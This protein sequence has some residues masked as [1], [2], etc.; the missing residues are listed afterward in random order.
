MSFLRDLVS[1]L[2]AELAAGL[3]LAA[4]AYFYLESLLDVRRERKQRFA[5][6]RDFLAVVGDELKRNREAR[7]VLEENLRRGALPYQAFEVGGWS[8]LSQAPVLTAVGRDTVKD[9]T[10]VYVKLRAANEQHAL[11]FDFTYGSTGALSVLLAAGSMTPAAR[12][13]YAQIEARREDLKER[14]L[15]RI[16]DLREPLER[17]GDAVT[18]EVRR[19]AHSYL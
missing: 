9:L 2:I 8:L 11:L 4:L 19:P 6:S 3:M 10:H 16:E 12:S 14:L 1:A 5:L 18:T 7:D 15:K 17:A 13:G